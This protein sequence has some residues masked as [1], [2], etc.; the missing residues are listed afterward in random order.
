MKHRNGQATH[1]YD[2]RKKSERTRHPPVAISAPQFR[3]QV[4][5]AVGFSMEGKTRRYFM[6][7]K[8]EICAEVFVKYVLAPMFKYDVPRIFGENKDSVVLDMDSPQCTPR[9]G[10]VLMVENILPKKNGYRIHQSCLHWII[11]P[12]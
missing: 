9:N 6:P 3:D 11:S 12:T 5:L 2:K 1:Y 10:F 8:T 7:R 4:M